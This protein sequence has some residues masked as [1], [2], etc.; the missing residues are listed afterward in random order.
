LGYNWIDIQWSYTYRYF[1]YQGYVLWVI[2]LFII[3]IIFFFSNVFFSIS[4]CVSLITTLFIYYYYYYF[5]FVPCRCT[6]GSVNDSQISASITISVETTSSTHQNQDC[7]P[8]LVSY[9][10]MFETWPYEDT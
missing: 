10:W 2:N 3:I 8:I 5:F 9:E 7:A 6:V 4:K 1:W